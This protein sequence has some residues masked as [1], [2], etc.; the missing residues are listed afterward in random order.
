MIGSKFRYSG[1]TQAQ[2]RQ[3]SALIDRPAPQFERSVS[4]RYMLARSID[5]GEI[6]S[7]FL[8]DDKTDTSTNSRA[9]GLAKTPPPLMLS[10]DWSLMFASSGSALGD[11]MDQLSQRS[12][13]DR[14][15]FMSR[16]DLDQEG[17]LD[18]EHDH[19]HYHDHD[20]NQSTDQELDPQEDEDQ[21]DVP[22]ASN[23]S[24]PG[25]TIELKVRN[26]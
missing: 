24:A 11:S 7:H 10:A 15:Q 14:T 4:K 13:S 8:K 23:M 5:G 21:E 9:L 22:R 18:L 17:S 1:R 16:E 3:A 25:R 26:Q 12:S 6:D 19:Y 2:T 20:Q